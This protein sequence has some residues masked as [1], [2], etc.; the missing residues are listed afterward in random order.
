MIDDVRQAEVLPLEGWRRTLNKI[1]QNWLGDGKK[2]GRVKDHIYYQIS[3]NRLLWIDS[4]IGDYS[5]TK[6]LEETK[7]AQ[8]PNL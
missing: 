2:K 6:E 1:L 8:K 5:S 4:K 7:Q 3:F